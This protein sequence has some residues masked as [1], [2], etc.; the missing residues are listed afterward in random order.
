VKKALICQILTRR[1]ANRV[2]DQEESEAQQHEVD[3]YKDDLTA[4]DAYRE[5]MSPEGRMRLT[6]EARTSGLDEGFACADPALLTPDPSGKVGSTSS[7]DSNIQA[8][9]KQPSSNPYTELDK[10]CSLYP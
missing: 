8:N 7:T 9:H 1:V 5:Y 3:P 10:V 6:K 4:L 2:R